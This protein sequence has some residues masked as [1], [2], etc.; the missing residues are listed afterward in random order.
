[1]PASLP[2]ASPE[3]IERLRTKP[4]GRYRHGGATLAA[5]A[6]ALGL[7]DEYRAR[8]YPVLVGGG[9]QFFP[10]HEHR[11]D[12]ELVE[13]RR[14]LESLAALPR[15]APVDGDVLPPGLPLRT[16]VASGCAGRTVP[17]RRLGSIAASRAA[18]PTSPSLAGAR[19]AAE[20]D[21]VGKSAYPHRAG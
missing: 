11:L 20:E 3:E 19:L 16:A 1:M 9:I 6:V 17:P 4:G 7:I 21:V 12:L 10:Q 14:Q 5:E 18:T 13:S 2:A 15:G 8:V